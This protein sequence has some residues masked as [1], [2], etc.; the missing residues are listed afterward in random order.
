MNV[1]QY[2]AVFEEQEVQNKESVRSSGYQCTRVG[3][4]D[5]KVG[6]DFCPRL[7]TFDNLAYE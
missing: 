2:M 4:Q 5:N 6:D 7:F 3:G 1:L